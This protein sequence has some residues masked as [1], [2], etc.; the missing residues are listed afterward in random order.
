LLVLFGG[1][2]SNLHCLVMYHCSPMGATSLLPLVQ[3]LVFLLLITEAA[4]TDDASD[5]PDD[6]DDSSAAIGTAF[7]TTISMATAILVRELLTARHLKR[8]GGRSFGSKNIIRKRACLLSIFNEYGPIFFKRAY[9]LLDLIEPNMRN[10]KRTRKCGRTPNGKIENETRL[11]IALRY[12]AGADPLDLIIVYKVSRAVVYESIWWVVEAVNTTQDLS[13]KYPTTHAK[14]K[15]VAEEFRKRSSVNFNNCAGCIDGVLIWIHRPSK[16]ELKKLNIGGRKFF[17]G[18][19]KKFGL[20]MQAVCDSNRRFLD[21]QIQHP[22]CTSDY[23][24]FILSKICKTLQNENPHENQKP[25]LSKGLAFYGDNAYVNCDFMVTP[26]KAVT[27]GPKDAYNFYVSQLRIIIE[28]AF[29]MLTR[30]W[31]ILRKAIPLN[32]SIQ[33]TVALVMA[34]CRLH[35]FCIDQR[36]IDILDATSNDAHDIALHGGLIWEPQEVRPQ[37]EDSDMDESYE[38]GVVGG[39]EGGD[40]ADGLNE[41]VNYVRLDELLDGGQHFDD[42]ARRQLRQPGCA[43]EYPSSKMLEYVTAQGFQRPSRGRRVR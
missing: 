21:V 38:E 36:D 32:I 29:G 34:L 5:S 30:R 2:F 10:Q 19:K 40:E 16:S 4:F 3:H 23:L 24:S 20:N 9:R 12:F 27:T 1:S 17:C 11:A 18:R 7:L 43:A 13:I 15:E 31:G 42:V 22:G 8:N 39:N 14:Q 25:F 26:Y 6:G 41:G 37:D 28:C 33:K 35:I